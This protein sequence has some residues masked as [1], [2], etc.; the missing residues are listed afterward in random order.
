MITLREALLLFETDAQKTARL[1][2]LNEERYGRKGKPS[3]W[4]GRR[5]KEQQQRKDDAEF[6]RRAEQA[7]ESE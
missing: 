4:W 2:A 6:N 7:K 1:K 3:H 5:V